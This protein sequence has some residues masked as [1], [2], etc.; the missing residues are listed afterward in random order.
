MNHHVEPAAMSAGAETLPRQLRFDP[1]GYPI[2]PEIP[3]ALLTRWKG[4]L[5]SCA[6]AQARMHNSYERLFKDREAC[7]R[8]MGGLLEDASGI[9]DDLRKLADLFGQAV[10]AEGVEGKLAEALRL[11][12]SSMTTMSYRID[13]LEKQGDAARERYHL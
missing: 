1:D 10:N 11:V 7:I 6:K 8:V 5:A 13:A 4:M 12:H 9:A 2:G 3:E